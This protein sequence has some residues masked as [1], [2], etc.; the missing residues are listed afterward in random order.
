MV[1]ERGRS[2]NRQKERAKG[3]Q[4]GTHRKSIHARDRTNDS[5]IN[6]SIVT[7]CRREELD[8]YETA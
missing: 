5:E 4:E 8:L 3:A 1:I 2:A 7:G 6:H